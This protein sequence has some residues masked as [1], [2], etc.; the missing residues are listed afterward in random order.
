MFK[1]QFTS[2][3]NKDAKKINKNNLKPKVE[4]LLEIIKKDPFQNPPPYKELLG[5][6]KGTHSRRIN[7]QHRLVYQILKEQ[8]IIKIIS[9]WDHY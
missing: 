7:I 1:L 6:L 2:Q 8:K 4:K 9:M 5:E 3:A